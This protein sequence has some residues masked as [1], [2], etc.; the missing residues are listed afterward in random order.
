MLQGMG[1]TEQVRR[2]P[3]RRPCHSSSRA[4]VAGSIFGHGPEDGQQGTDSGS[5]PQVEKGPAIALCADTLGQNG[6]S[7]LPPLSQALPDL[8]SLVTPPLPRSC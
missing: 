7:Q 1:S 6:P 8:R 5:P 2:G 3:L 4:E